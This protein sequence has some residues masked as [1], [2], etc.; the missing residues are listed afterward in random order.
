MQT[1]TQVFSKEWFNNPKTQQRLLWLLNHSRYFRQDLGIQECDLPHQ[2]KIT[3]V[4]PNSFSY[5]DRPFMKDGQLMIER[6]TDFRTHDKFG[7]RLYYG[8]LPVWEKVHKF[9]LKIANRFAP[10][11]NMGF[12]TLTAYPVAGNNSPCD[13]RAYIFSVGT[14]WSNIVNGAGTTGTA[15]DSNNYYVYIFA[16]S[17]SPDW[18]VNNR[19]IFLFDTSGLDAL[20][21]ITISAA[22]LSLRGTAKA[23]DGTA[24]SPNID[25]YTSNPASTSTIVAS[26]Y[27]N[28]GSIS[29]TGSPISY[30][31]FSA[32]GYNDFPFNATGIGNIS[33][34]GISKFGARNANYDVS[35]STPTWSS[36]SEH[37]M[38]GYYAD[39]TGTDNDPKLVVTYTL[40]ATSN[41]LMF[42]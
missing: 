33:I 41:F 14:T 21:D 22:T 32:S 38:T 23:D 1:P 35:G 36:S 31:S 11:L 13:G 42:M 40:P 25:I 7:K 28:L 5:G 15:T 26:D 19:S 16:S 4:T 12:D 29:Q 17:G 10:A 34:D 8:F 3:A 18:S 24:I 37:S 9:D 30:A 20:G 39:Q 27:S 2:E 6:T